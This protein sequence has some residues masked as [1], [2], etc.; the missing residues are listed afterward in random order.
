MRCGILIIGSLLWDDPDGGQRADWREARLD[1]GAA[2]RVGTPIRYGRK[3]S[4][5]ANT[6]T[7]IFNPGDPV[8]EAVVLPCRGDIATLNDLVAESKALWQ[9]EA[10]ANEP[11]AIS[12]R[13]GCVGAMF[14]DSATCLS[15]EWSAH[16]R[17]CGAR[18][19]SV[20]NADGILE[21]CWPVE[22]DDGPANF[23]LIL[24]TATAPAATLP[25]AEMVADAWVERGSEEY[26]LNNVKHG[27]RTA[28]D[29]EIWR[30]IKERDPAWLRNGAHTQAINLLNAEAA[31]GRNDA[32]ESS[33]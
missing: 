33:R 23:D 31:R 28:G 26:F 24:A 7:M 5:R 19:V 1:S 2:V 32:I 18:P 6:F 17:K 25:T 12:E 3:S 20:V 9:A 8:G 13:W 4:S 27:I 10:R 22:L 16:F 15:E 21:M 30:R 14:A 11:G 29:G